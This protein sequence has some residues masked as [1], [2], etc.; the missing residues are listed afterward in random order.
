MELTDQLARIL[1]NLSILADKELLK[2]WKSL[3]YMQK[4]AF[5]DKPSKTV[6]TLQFTRIFQSKNSA[7]AR[8]PAG[9]RSAC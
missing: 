6:A 3:A 9:A 1:S 5:N 2:P 4:Y 7:E 8:H